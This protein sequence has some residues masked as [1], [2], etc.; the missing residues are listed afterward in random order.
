[1]QYLVDPYSSVSVNHRDC[2]NGENPSVELTLGLQHNSWIIFNI[3]TQ[4]MFLELG[5]GPAPGSGRRWRRKV[6]VCPLNP[7]RESETDG[8]ESRVGVCCGKLT[9]VPGNRIFAEYVV[10]KKKKWEE[11][12]KKKKQ[13]LGVHESPLTSLV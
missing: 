5:S 9:S 2:K 3:V 6:H 13:Q 12:K 1:M 7:N 11:E 4:Q 10:K 8:G